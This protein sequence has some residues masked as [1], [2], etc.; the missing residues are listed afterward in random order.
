[1]D[2]A[3]LISRIRDLSTPMK[4][5]PTDQNPSLQPLKEVHCVAFDFYGTMFISGVGDIGIDEEQDSKGW[6]LFNQALEDTGFK[7]IQKDA[8]GKDYN[9]LAVKSAT[10]RKNSVTGGS[11]IQNQI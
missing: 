5:L 7:I 3:T 11:T 10:T 1:M 4:P 2:E 9:D 8:S 6:S